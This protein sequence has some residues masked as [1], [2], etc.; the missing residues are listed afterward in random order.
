[1]LVSLP[2]PKSSHKNRLL[3]HIFLAAFTAAV[4]G[5]TS[6]DF[7][8][9]QSGPGVWI[10]GP[11]TERQDREK[12]GEWAF[13]GDAGWRRKGGHGAEKEPGTITSRALGE[14]DSKLRSRRRETRAAFG[15]KRVW[16]VGC[17]FGVCNRRTSSPHHVIWQSVSNSSQWQRAVTGPGWL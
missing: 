6:N 4:S 3:P 5:P 1:M 12:W 16:S 7:N 13:S 8:H 17:P 11:E 10:S 14:H 9:L 15:L 2:T